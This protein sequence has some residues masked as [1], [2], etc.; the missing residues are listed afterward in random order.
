MLAASSASALRLGAGGREHARSPLTARGRC[1]MPDD[2]HGLRHDILLER[3]IAIA[4]ESVASGLLD[5]TEGRTFREYMVCLEGNI[6]TL[7]G[8][9][10]LVR[11]PV[12]RRYHIG[13]KR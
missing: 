11:S 12:R 1:N 5:A 8:H 13:Q 10:N 4:T 9:L 2:A 3:A 7:N 6:A